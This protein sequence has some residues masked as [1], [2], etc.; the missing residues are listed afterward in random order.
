M[1]G[2]LL[3]PLIFFT[4][5][6]PER[7]GN[8]GNVCPFLRCCIWMK[9]LK[10]KEFKKEGKSVINRRNM[11]AIEFILKKLFKFEI[12]TFIYTV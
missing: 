12:S 8:K 10:K 6:E 4:M 2:L 1:P 7:T 9:Y 11:P 5:K 3:G